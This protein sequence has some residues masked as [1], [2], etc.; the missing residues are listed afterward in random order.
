MHAYQSHQTAA[1]CVIRLPQ[2]IEMTGMSRSTIWR[3]VRTD[4]DFPKPFK[5]SRNI[6]VWSQNSIAA[7]LAAKQRTSAA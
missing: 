6:T 4:P 7:W 1:G 5:L 2:V 3:L